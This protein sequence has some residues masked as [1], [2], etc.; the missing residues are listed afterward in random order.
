MPASLKETLK[1]GATLVADGAMGTELQ[2][3]GLEPGGC[4]DEWN[5]LHPDRVLAIHNAYVEA[6]SQVL[7]TNTFGSNRFVLARYGLESRAAEICRA[8]AQIAR[9]A[10]RNRGW[11]LGDVGPC[12]GFLEP[13]GDIAP[14]ALEDSLRE[15]IGALLD[16]GVDAIILE[17]M[18]ALEEIEIGVRVAREMGAPCVVASM[19]YDRVRGLY[20]GPDYKT[21]MGVAPEQAARALVAAG[22]DVVGANCGSGLEPRDFVHLAQRFRGACDAPL[23]LQPNAGQPR[24]EGPAVVYPVAPEEFAAALVELARQAQIVGGCCGSTPAHI[25]AFRRALAAATS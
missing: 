12:G 1:S 18:T 17:T 13:L 3:A 23:A 10:I 9:Q 20:E 11:V 22:A 6:G 19:A 21:M 16:G 25:R 8:G 4:G 24:L 5:V 14:A 7:I 15:Q 2:R